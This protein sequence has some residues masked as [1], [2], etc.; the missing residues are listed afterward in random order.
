M[1]RLARG[2]LPWPARL[3]GQPACRGSLTAEAPI[4]AGARLRV[5]AW[6]RSGPD[7][8]SWLSLEVEPYPKGGRGSGTTAHKRIS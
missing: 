1:T 8:T 6:L 5:T 2:S 3:A 4:D 7:G